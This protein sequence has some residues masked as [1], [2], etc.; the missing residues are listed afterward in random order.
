MRELAERLEEGR[1]EGGRAA[2]REAAAARPRRAR[3]P[4][5]T[6]AHPDAKAA[7]VAEGVDHV[8][9]RGGGG[10]GLRYRCGREG[11]ACDC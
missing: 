4:P 7:H 3:P 5:R 6:H 10:G 8:A 11:L 1:R 2:V 9:A